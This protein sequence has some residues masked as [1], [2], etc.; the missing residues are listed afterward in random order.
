MGESFFLAPTEEVLHSKSILPH[1]KSTH[2]S[3]PQVLLKILIYLRFSDGVSPASFFFLEPPDFELYGVSL[4]FA[5]PFFFLFLPPSYSKSES[6]SGSERS[7]YIKSQ[8][9]S[10]ILFLLY[11]LQKATKKREKKKKASY[12]KPGPH[13]HLHGIVLLVHVIVTPLHCFCC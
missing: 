10:S 2:Q 7:S 13:P 6:L 1:K 8:H 9:M 5:L 11:V 3:L 12:P 4:L